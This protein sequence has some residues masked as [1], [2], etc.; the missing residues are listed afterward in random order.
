MTEKGDMEI[1][2]IAEY[3]W[4]VLKAVNDPEIGVNVVDLGLIYGIDLED[5]GSDGISASV[6]MTLTTAGCPLAD[7][8]ANAVKTAI[9]N[10]GKCSSVSVN[11]TF[12][13][14]WNADMMTAEGKMQLGLL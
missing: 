3:L 5:H 6:E 1:A 12:D 11:L 9:I 2:A 10:S 4:D 7:V 13:P 8:I 14:P